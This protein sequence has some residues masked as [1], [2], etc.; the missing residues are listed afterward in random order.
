MT[1]PFSPESR[2]DRRALNLAVVG[3]SD[4]AATYH[5]PALK[6]LEGL[7]D[8]KRAPGASPRGE[9]PTAVKAPAGGVAPPVS[10]GVPPIRVCGIWNR[11]ALRAESAARRFDI[12]RVYRS[13]QE[14]L[15]DEQV[16]CFVVLVNPKVLPEIV[17]ELL[18]R[19]LP[20]FTEKSP[21]WSCHQ[22]R[23]LAEAV[24]VTN[25]VGFNR[26]YMPLNRRFKS[27][28]DDLAAPY[29]VEC[30]FYRHE[31][32]CSEFIIETGVHGINFLEYLCGPIAEVRTDRRRNPRN[33][34]YVWECRLDFASGL[35]AFAKF[36][37]C[38]G[39]SIERF[40][41]HGNESS[42]YLHSPQT[43]SSDYPGRILVHQ[44]GREAQTIEGSSEA[45]VLVN[46]GFIDEYLD[47]FEGIASG[48]ATLSNFQ[49]AWSTMAVA[50]AIERGTDYRR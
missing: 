19:R 11:T 48:R 15:E 13:L 44:G 12:L 23:V 16:D 18:P 27:I 43:Y 34:T 31:R 40:E 1:A 49:N 32:L 35:R 17:A 46:S 20:L 50:E 38:C 14:L 8:T 4:W 37:P 10:G 3:A 26:R 7:S 28:V 36:L 45:G 6:L 21:G 33:G 41:V 29:F 39:S 22:A 30:H 24:T 47:F 25:V 9:P 2:S 42:V 5:L